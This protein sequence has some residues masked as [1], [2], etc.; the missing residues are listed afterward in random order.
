M[1]SP[2]MSTGTAVLGG[3]DLAIS[4]A[5]FL[6]G[7]LCAQFAHYTNVN[8][9]DGLWLKLFVTGLA[10]L[11]TLKTVKVLGVMW[12]QNVT[13]FED[14]GAVFRLWATHWVPKLSPILEALIAVYVQG[15][16]CRRLRTISGNVYIVILCM[17]AFAFALVSGIVAVF[18]TFTKM[19]SP[20]YSTWMSIHLGA[21]LCADLLLTGSTAF[22]LL[23]HSKTVLP[24]GPTAPI[25]N[26]L[27]RVTIQSAAPAALCAFINFV[28]VVLLNGRTAIPVSATIGGGSNTV[29]PQLYAWSAM[30]TLNSREDIHLAADNNRYTLHPELQGT[31]D[32]ETPDYN[33][34]G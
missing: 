13:L 21:A 8:T 17:I 20:Q 3:L 22:Y 2:R 12:M 29:L 7:V 15:F 14:S 24:R 33:D 34:H 16:F 28:A 1:P 25:L 4:A 31:S 23:R 10:L 18:F 6:Q 27:L 11:T 19:S 26:S 30:W 5:V 9:R 32:S